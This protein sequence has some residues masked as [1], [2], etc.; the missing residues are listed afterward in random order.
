MI[1]VIIDCNIIIIIKRISTI[2]NII[3]III[4]LN[5]LINIVI[6]NII[7]INI[8]LIGWSSANRYHRKMIINIIIEW[9]IWLWSTKLSDWWFNWCKKWRRNFILGW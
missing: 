3:T 1:V 6:T 4:I 8:I 5:I 7:L 9:I 2:L